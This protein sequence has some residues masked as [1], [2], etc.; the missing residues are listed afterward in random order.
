MDSYSKDDMI[1][2]RNQAVERARQMQRRSRLPY[3][4]PRRKSV[5]PTKV[6]PAL[7][8]P[9]PEKPREPR[10]QRRK[11][12]LNILEKLNIGSLGSL[13]FDPDTVL[14]IMLIILLYGESKNENGDKLLI[15]A[16]IYLLL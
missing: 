9:P 4:E 12:G 3:E 8:S 7:P 13:K 10:R 6:S 14:I 1:K 16:L 2:M 15:Y 5:T 11:G